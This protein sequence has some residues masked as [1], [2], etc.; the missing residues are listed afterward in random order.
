MRI[1]KGENEKIRTSTKVVMV[2]KHIRYILIYDITPIRF[3]SIE[4]GLEE[5]G[6]EESLYNTLDDFSVCA[7]GNTKFNLF[8]QRFKLLRLY[9][10]SCFIGI[11]LTLEVFY[12]RSRFRILLNGNRF[13]SL[14]F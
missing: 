8:F 4:T 14:L 11:N 10:K 9:S 7:Y 3:F 5:C 1:G 12:Q 2:K 6:Y 13:F